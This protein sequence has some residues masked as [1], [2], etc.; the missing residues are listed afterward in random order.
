MTTNLKYNAK[1]KQANNN[2][3]FEKILQ[4]VNRIIISQHD[5]VFYDQFLNVIRTTPLPAAYGDYIN[6][7]LPYEYGL[8]KYQPKTE[9]KGQ[10]INIEI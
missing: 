3:V 6:I 2:Q 7:E 8:E 10:E 5:V 4:N 1:N 9:A